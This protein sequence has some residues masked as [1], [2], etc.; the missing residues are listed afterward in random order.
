MVRKPA[1]DGRFIP[2]EPWGLR[3]ENPWRGSE[4]GLGSTVDVYPTLLS[5]N[6]I[7]AR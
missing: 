1:A 5:P 7:E 3:P 2:P 6:R 4:Q